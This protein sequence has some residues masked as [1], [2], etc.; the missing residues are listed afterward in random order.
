MII[1]CFNYNLINNGDLESRTFDCL[2]TKMYRTAINLVYAS[3]VR[4]AIFFHKERS[5][6]AAL[7]S[8]TPM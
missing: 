8:L 1:R 3:N 4:Y 2:P 6:H 5:A 7:R